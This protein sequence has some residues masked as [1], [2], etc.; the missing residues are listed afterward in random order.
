MSKSLNFGVETYLVEF[1]THVPGHA[2]KVE[3]NRTGLQSWRNFDSSYMDDIIILLNF[4]FTGLHGY[5]I[6]Q[7]FNETQSYRTEKF[8][9]SY[10]H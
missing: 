1:D 5:K 2:S 8:L 7:D 4:I 9:L 6:T 10:E 3:L